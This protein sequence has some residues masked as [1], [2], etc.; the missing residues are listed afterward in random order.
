MTSSELKRLAAV[1]KQKAPATRVASNLAANCA[2][3]LKSLGIEQLPSE[4]KCKLFLMVEGV[5][6]NE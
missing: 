4:G 3:V 1:S 5:V 6:K 2:D